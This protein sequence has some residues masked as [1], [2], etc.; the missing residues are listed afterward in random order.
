[1][2]AAADAAAAFG[3]RVGL[4]GGRIAAPILRY[5]KDELPRVFGSARSSAALGPRRILLEGDWGGGPSFARLADPEDGFH[6]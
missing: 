4:N 3:Y 1:M 6:L 5:L 2:S